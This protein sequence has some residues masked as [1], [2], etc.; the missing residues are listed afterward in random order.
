MKKICVVRRAYYPSESHTRR[1]AECLASHG[2]QVDVICL[3]KRT[4]RKRE[5]INGVNVIR[6]PVTHERKGVFNYILEYVSFFVLVFIKLSY[7]QIKNKY[8]LIEV[9]TIPD[10]LVFSAVIPK[11]MGRKIIV[12]FFEDMP[13]IMAIKYGLSEK[14]FVIRL[15]HWVEKMSAR[16]ADYAIVCHE[17][18]HRKLVEKRKVKTPVNVV[19]NVPDENVFKPCPNQPLRSKDDIFTL[20]HHGT[21][22]ENYGI[23]TIVKAVSLLKGRMNIRLKIYGRGEYLEELNSLVN[24]L[25]VED[26]V[27]FMGYVSYDELLEGLCAGDA[28]V[29][30]LLNEYQS[31]NKLFEL[32]T[33]KRPVLVSDLQ[34]IKQHFDIDSVQYFKT[35]SPDDLA[36]KIFDL[37]QNTERRASL[38]MNASNLYEQYKWTHMKNRYLDVYKGLLHE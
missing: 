31:P 37:A 13:E 18:S 24:K 26:N 19:M 23:Q 1:N 38:V 16:F 15:L 3:G 20:T 6:L 35:G 7:L 33:L 8:D 28:G 36:D 10:F 4:R 29:V 14:H 34:T 5:T 9:E 12:Y 21:V 30:A 32:V 22:T 11:L 27:L 2:Y 25:G 17:I